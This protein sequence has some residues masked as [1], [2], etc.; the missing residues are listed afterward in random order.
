MDV[1]MENIKQF[2][3]KS[4]YCI[5]FKVAMTVKLKNYMLKLKLYEKHTKVKICD[6]C[7]NTNI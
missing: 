2:E 5:H 6:K 7:D 3:Y 1:L 4:K